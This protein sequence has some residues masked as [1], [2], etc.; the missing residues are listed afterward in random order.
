MYNSPDPLLAFRGERG[1]F[2]KRREIKWKDNLKKIRELYAEH[3]F[4]QCASLCDTAL[5]GGQVKSSL[6]KS[7]SHLTN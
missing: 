2:Q 1:T 7:S 6:P 5:S 3:R 4:R